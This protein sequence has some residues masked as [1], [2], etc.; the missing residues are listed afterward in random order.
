M[1]LLAIVM[2]MLVVGWLLPALAATPVGSPAMS[3]QRRPT[4]RPRARGPPA[5]SST[6]DT[7]GPGPTAV[8]PRPRYPCPSTSYP[9]IACRQTG[10]P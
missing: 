4:W 9:P 6:I 2:A 10:D 1:I 5:E 8:R 3:P 7:N